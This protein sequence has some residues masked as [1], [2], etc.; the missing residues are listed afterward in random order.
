[1]Q[2]PALGIN[3]IAGRRYYNFSVQKASMG[4]SRGQGEAPAPHYLCQL[5]NYIQ[6]YN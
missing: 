1:M 6:G 2:F 5:P 3:S 4:N